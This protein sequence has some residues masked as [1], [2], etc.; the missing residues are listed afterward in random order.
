MNRLIKKGC[1]GFIF[2]F[3]LV[4]FGT[5]AFTVESGGTQVFN[6]GK[7]DTSNLEATQETY[8]QLSQKTT[9]AA[10]ECMMN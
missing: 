2:Y 3:V 9:Q 8:L 1:T 5:A 4:I 7:E 6:T 10:L